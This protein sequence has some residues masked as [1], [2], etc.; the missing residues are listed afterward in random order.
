MDSGE[1]QLIKRFANALMVGGA[2]LA[3]AGGT[4]VGT[5]AGGASGAATTKVAV[6][7]AS[8]NVA[9]DAESFSVNI[10]AENVNNLAAF[11]FTIQFDNDILEYVGLV[12]GGYLRSTG[13]QQQCIMPARG[14]NGESAAATANQYGAFN[15]GCTTLGITVGNEG[16][17]GPSGTGTLATVTFKP[18]AAGDADVRLRGY[19]GDSEMPFVIRPA[20]NAD[21]NGE[22]GFTDLSPVEV[23]GT[24]EEGG[25]CAPL[26]MDFDVQNGVVRVTAAGEPTPTGVPATPTQVTRQ[27]TPDMQATAQAVLGTPGRTLDR[28]PAAGAGTGSGAGSSGRP[29]GTVAGAGAQGGQ[30]GGA[31]APVAGYGP[32]QTDNPWP[33]RAGAALAL[34]GIIAVAAGVT[35]RRRLAS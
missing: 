5:A 34:T 18:K 9:A 24:R 14:P 27:P 12:D 35:V 17:D 6:T 28:T 31:G 10:S 33:E 26:V 32:R 1:G 19:P 8:Q 11:N 16:I 13:R 2:T 22:Q 15:F 4:V 21:D 20:A 23:C 3:L 7:P 25:N 30:Q 29:S